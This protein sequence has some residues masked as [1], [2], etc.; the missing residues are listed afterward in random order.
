MRLDNAQ[1]NSIIRQYEEQQSYNRQ[2]LNARVNEVYDRIP[3][4]REL[5]EQLA[6]ESI[7]LTKL[8]LLN[9]DV[10]SPDI[11]G[12]TRSITAQKE[13]LLSS[14][15]YPSDYLE[16]QY[17]CPD[18]KDTGYLSDNEKCHCLK[19]KIVELLYSTSNLHSTLNRENFSTFSY[20]YYND[21][22]TDP[23]LNKT[24]LENIK[25]VVIEA[26]EFINDFAKPY[27]RRNLLIY[28]NPGV[29][30]TFLAN[31]IAKELL[32]KFHNV[33]YLT[34]LHLFDILE[35]YKFSNDKFTLSSDY[36]MILDCDL[37]IIDD[38][39]TELSTT[40]TNSQLYMCINERHLRGKSTV[41]STN[42]SFEALQSTY[43]ERIFSRIIENYTLLKIIGD[44]IR[45][46][47]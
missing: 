1:Y 33:L 36:D 34:A 31:C 3:A 26:K 13:A 29:G 42:L 21:Q 30:K 11:E 44:D 40:F 7:R 6:S 43:S 32:D 38:L 28:G 24:P 14:Y 25:R 18:C 9:K 8:S 19:Q 39:G 15:G 20:A 5:N 2:A 47:N 35:R 23:V 17:K 10:P 27:N 4:I 22:Y 41:I 46:G 12:L 37:L 45:A 16:L